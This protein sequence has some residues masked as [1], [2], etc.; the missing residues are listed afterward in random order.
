MADPAPPPAIEADAPPRWSAQT[1]WEM[2]T[3]DDSSGLRLVI[4][5][6]DQSEAAEL[7]EGKAEASSQP[8]TMLRPE[9]AELTE[10]GAPAAVP[11]CDLLLG[12]TPAAA[13]VRCAAPS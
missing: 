6:D 3:D 9:P 7:A 11:P 4:C 13:I 1:T 5:E 12:A 10:S 2:S 8:L